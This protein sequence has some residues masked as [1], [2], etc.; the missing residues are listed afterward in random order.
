MAEFK[1]ILRKPGE[2][3]RSEE[4]NTIQEGLLAEISKLEQKL[5]SLKDYV[6]NMSERITLT[7][8][9]SV[10]GRSYALDEEVPGESSHYRIKSMGLITRQWVTAVVGEGDVCHFGV[11]D[12][13]DILYY[14]AGAENGNQEMLDIELEYSDD[15]VSKITENGYVNDKNTLSESVGANPYIEFLYS[16]FGIWYKYQVKNPHPENEVRIIRFRNTKADCNPRI[17]N[18]IQLKTKV[19]QLV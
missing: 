5:A 16:D 19:H 18:T 10:T 4:W 12:Y 8:L 11:T 1:P 15:S 14:W 13:F 3:I 2:V 6:D 17:G 9:E 7:G